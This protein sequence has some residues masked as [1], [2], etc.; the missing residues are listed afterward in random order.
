[1]EVPKLGVELEV[2]LQAYTTAT[3]VQDRQPPEQGQESNLLPR[4]Y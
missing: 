2:Q 3:A 4:G 1:M